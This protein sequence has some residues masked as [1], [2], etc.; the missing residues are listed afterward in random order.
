MTTIGKPTPTQAECD[1]A[2]MG[3]TPDPLEPDGS[4][5]FVYQTVAVP[6]IATTTMLA[7][8]V[9]AAPTTQPPVVPPAE[10]TTDLRSQLDAMTKSEV[11]AEADLRGVSYPDGA[12]KIEIIDAIVAAA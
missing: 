4:Q 5:E 8:T 10:G 6:D 2:A 3:M 1:L 12:T 11:I 9:P 7:P